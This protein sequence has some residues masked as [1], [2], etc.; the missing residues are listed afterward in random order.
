MT[1]EDLKAAERRVYRHFY[2][3][4]RER[5]IGEIRLLLHS[6]GISIPQ[7]QLRNRLRGGFSTIERMRQPLAPKTQG[8][9][10][11]ATRL[12]PVPRTAR[13]ANAPVECTECGA[14]SPLPMGRINSHERYRC[15]RCGTI[16]E[17]SA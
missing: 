14:G 1:A 15:T 7:P 10:P 6:K 8:H 5:T 2:F 13:P 12:D 17:V 11:P 16:F 3:E 9:R 4:G